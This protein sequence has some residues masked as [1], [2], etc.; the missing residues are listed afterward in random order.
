V[1]TV[2][3]GDFEWDYAKA[4]ANLR[5][6]RVSFSEACEVF[7]DPL[8]I[9]APDRY[10]PHRFVIIGR[11]SRDRVLFVVHAVLNEHGHVRI[12][13]ARRASP[14]QRKAFFAK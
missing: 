13:S 9:D 1:S 8:A 10:V 12:I 14:T 4:H 7:D 2:H 5:K 6:H 3:F 11:S